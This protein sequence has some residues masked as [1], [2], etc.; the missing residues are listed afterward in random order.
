MEATYIIDPAKMK[1][2]LSKYLLGQI[3]MEEV[4]EEYEI[5]MQQ[6]FQDAYN[7]AKHLSETTAITFQEA[8][9]KEIEKLKK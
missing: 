9:D 3:S 2:P 8:L 5:I 7:R 1:D 4:I 6:E